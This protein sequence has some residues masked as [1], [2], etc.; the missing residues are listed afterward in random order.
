MND[1]QKTDPNQEV[2]YPSPV[3]E[4]CHSLRNDNDKNCLGLNGIFEFCQNICI[5]NN[6]PTVSINLQKVFYPKNQIYISF[7]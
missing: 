6:N 2:E 5:R 3:K 1:F 4:S 7:C